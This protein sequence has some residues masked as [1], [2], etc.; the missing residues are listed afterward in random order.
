MDLD[1]VAEELYALRPEEFVAARDRRALDARASG[2]P[3]LARRIG[4][5]RRPSLSAWVSNLLVRGQPQQVEPLLGL[6]EELRRAH[7]ELDGPE[8][9]R[10]ARRQNEVIG[11]L[12]RQARQLAAEAGHPVGESVQR[13]VEETLHA[14][15]AD[16]QAARE[17]AGGRLVKP[18]SSAVGFPAADETALERRP[19]ARRAGPGDGPPA[20]R[21]RQDP[22]DGR[23]PKGNRASA[24]TH[25][26]RAGAS[27]GARGPARA[28]VAADERGAG[29]KAAADERGA[30]EKAAADKRGPGEKAAADERRR[31]A[32]HR[33]RLDRVRGEARSAE[34]EL[35]A[36]E[37]EAETADREAEEAAG[38][39]REATE[40]LRE[41]LAELKRA[42]DG[43]RQART[44][45]QTARDRARQAGRAVR[46]A[47]EETRRAAR[48]VREAERRAGAAGGQPAR[49]PAQ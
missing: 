45:E 20:E 3:A 9:R 36:R 17:W 19:A 30:G 48:V 33:R 23:R 1:T 43:H 26:G 2:D 38:R 37:A 29:E 46:D 22:A 25:R 7:R 5:L 15:L 41:L 14:A 49:T 44:D 34:R 28:R 12:G 18:L 6:G 31:A 47:R 10:L 27:A 32:E 8:L 39:L 4:A 42:E 21:E 35:R 13:E 16:P 24:A 11:A 40:R